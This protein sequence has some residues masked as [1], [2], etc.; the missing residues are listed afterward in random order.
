L[1][2][3]M[4]TA[5]VISSLSRPHT[6]HETVEALARQTISPCA[7]VVSLCDAQSVLEETARLSLV[8][9]T[10]GAKGLTK[11]RNNA[12]QELPADAEYVLFL[13][14]DVEL[15]AN[16]LE[17]MEGVFGAQPD[18]VLAS[19]AVCWADGPRLGRAV[20]RVEAVASVAQHRCENKIVESD[21]AYGCNMFV[22]RSMLQHERF[23][24]RLPLGSWLEDYDFSVRCGR[25][26]RV[27]WNHGTCVAHLG[28]QRAK[29]ERGFPVGYA[30]IANSY[31]LWQKGVIPSLT[32]LL[33]AF[34][35]PALR[36]SLQGTLHGKPPW[37][38]RFDYKGRLRGNVRALF[39]AARF[40]LKP[41]RILDFAEQR[42]AADSTG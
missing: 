2:K 16:Y 32:R 34:W 1:G 8:C 20:T 11:Q 7:I 31:Y 38:E 13:D 30:Q 39:D 36:V 18:I 5:I 41:E 10:Y 6:L 23:D 21:G 35:L 22:R 33:G 3:A 17:T 19:G 15:A 26:G 24:E 4:K 28:V 29:R 25:H 42:A 37:N 27:V 14:D 40:R 12:L 9:V